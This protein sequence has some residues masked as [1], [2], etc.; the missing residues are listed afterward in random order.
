MRPGFPN[1][2]YVGIELG[3]DDASAQGPSVFIDKFAEELGFGALD[4]LPDP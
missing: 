3:H 1:A 4:T 2:V